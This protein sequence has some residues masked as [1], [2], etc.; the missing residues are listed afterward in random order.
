[1][2]GVLVVLNAF[3]CCFVDVKRYRI[4]SLE[5]LAAMELLKN[6]IV[7]LLLLL[8]GAFPL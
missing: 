5:D 8:H 4:T 7:K 1:M 2:I 6:F 3:L